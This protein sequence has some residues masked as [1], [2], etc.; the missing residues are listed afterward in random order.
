MKWRNYLI[1]TVF[2]V[3]IFGLGMSTVI[4]PIKE[5]SALENRRLAQPPSIGLQ[6]FVEGDFTQQFEEFFTDQF[7]LRDSWVKGYKQLRGMVSQLSAKVQNTDFQY[8]DGFYITEDGWIMFKPQEVFSQEEILEAAASLNQLGADLTAQGVELYFVLLPNKLATVRLNLPIDFATEIIENKELLLSFLDRDKVQV[9]DLAE[10]IRSSFNELQINSLYFKTDHHWNMDGAFHSYLTFINWLSQTSR[11]QIAPIAQEQYLR[12]CRQDINFMGS[13]NRQLAGI[14]EIQEPICY[15]SPADPE[16]SFTNLEVYMGSRGPENRTSWEQVYASGLNN[17]VVFYSD[18]Y[19]R[20]YREINIYNSGNSGGPSLL[21][22][23]DSYTN[24]IIFHIA[25]HFYRT[26]IF[27][28]R[29]N[30]DRSLEEY[31]KDNSFDI[32]VVMYN[33]RAISGEIYQFSWQD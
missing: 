19:T 20:D 27:D 17:D 15:Y 30:Q 25:N 5:V 3:Y 1:I 31:L 28:I 6:P 14:V 23:K 32:V 29:H 2:L 18:A 10:E 24:P 13:W 16:Q 11:F 12:E 26:T 33:E 9:F 4:G 7:V 22:I 21:L 8:I